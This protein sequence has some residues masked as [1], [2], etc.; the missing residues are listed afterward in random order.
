MRLPSYEVSAVKREL[1]RARSK[2]ELR[3]AGDGRCP[4]NLVSGRIDRSMT[5]IPD[6]REGQLQGGGTILSNGAHNGSWANDGD[7]PTLDRCEET[8]FA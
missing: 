7:P 4:S 2:A 5:T 8:L 3:V 6:I 1:P